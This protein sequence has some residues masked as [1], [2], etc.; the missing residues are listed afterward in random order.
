M[1]SQRWRANSTSASALRVL[2]MSAF[3]GT[4]LMVTCSYRCSAERSST[5]RRS[6]AWRAD[7]SP[8]TVRSNENSGERHAD[9]FAAGAPSF[10]VDVSLSLRNEIEH[11][12]HPWGRPPQLDL[13]ANVGEV[14]GDPADLAYAA[15]VD[16]LDI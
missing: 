5:R 7:S 8:E 6:S 12:L 1:S 16:P 11:F 9:S 2:A 13:A 15:H 4:L 3:R 14:G 10:L